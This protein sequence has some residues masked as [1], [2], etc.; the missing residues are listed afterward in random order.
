MI[1]TQYVTIVH[2]RIYAP[3][4]LT[5][6]GS[7]KLAGDI[8]ACVYMYHS[9]RVRVATMRTSVIASVSV[10]VCHTG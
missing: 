6:H 9:P 3:C 4:Q 5:R 2:T 10:C 7:E 8:Y 1:E